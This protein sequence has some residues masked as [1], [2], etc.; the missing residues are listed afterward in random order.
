[1]DPGRLRRRQMEHLQEG[2]VSAAIVNL[3]LCFIFLYMHIFFFACAGF[4]ILFICLLI[5][6]FGSMLHE[7]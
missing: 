5:S 7:R 1:M 4:G 6:L 2:K 3:V